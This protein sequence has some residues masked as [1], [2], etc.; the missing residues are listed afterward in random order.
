MTIG[1]STS[2]WCVINTRSNLVF[3]LIVGMSKKQWHLKK[4]PFVLCWCLIIMDVIP[5]GIEPVSKV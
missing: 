3:S 5:T 4:M 2:L 1:D